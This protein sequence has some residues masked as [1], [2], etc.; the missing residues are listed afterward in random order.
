MISSN[1]VPSYLE[2]KHD[3]KIVPVVF[4]LGVGKTSGTI[5]YCEYHSYKY[6]IVV[7]NISN[8][9]DVL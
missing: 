8:I 7:P 9:L 1:P 4:P 3:E 5:E 6:L 2:Y